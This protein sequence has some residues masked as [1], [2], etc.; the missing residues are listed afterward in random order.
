MPN[1]MLSYSCFLIYIDTVSVAHHQRQGNIHMILRNPL[2]D[3]Q[4]RLLVNTV[5]CVG[6]KDTEEYR[7]RKL[8]ADKLYF[9]G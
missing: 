2:H 5:D 6:S 3:E 4:C 8:V 7:N 9:V 1:D